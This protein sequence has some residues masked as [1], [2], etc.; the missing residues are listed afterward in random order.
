MIQVKRQRRDMGRRKEIGFEMGMAWKGREG[1]KRKEERKEG[2]E[3]KKMRWELNNTRDEKRRD[4]GGKERRGR[5][6][7]KVRII[8]R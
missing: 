6:G 2:G 5:K 8:S 7:K 3:E 1:K 4:E